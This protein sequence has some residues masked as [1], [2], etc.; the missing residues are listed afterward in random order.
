MYRLLG[1]QE[2]TDV[3]EQKPSRDFVRFLAYQDGE[4]VAVERPGI[5]QRVAP[6]PVGG[7]LRGLVDG[8]GPTWLGVL[9]RDRIVPAEHLLREVEPEPG[10]DRQVLHEVQAAVH[11]AEHPVV[12]VAIELAVRGIAER[13]GVVPQADGLAGGEVPVDVV[14]RDDG[15]HQDILA[16]NVVFAEV[17]VRNPAEGLLARQRDVPAHDE[18][19]HVERGVDA[20]GAALQPVEGRRSLLIQEI[21]RRVV[22][23]V[24]TA[25]RNTQVGV[26]GLSRT[27]YR[28]PPVRPGA[29][30]HDQRRASVGRPW[31]CVR[32]QVERI[33]GLMFTVVRKDERRNRWV[34]AGAINA[35]DGLHR[36]GDRIPLAYATVTHGIAITPLHDLVVLQR[37]G[38]QKIVVATER[39]RDAGSDIQLHFPRSG[40][41]LPRLD[42]HHA[43]AGPRPV[44]RRRRR[45]FQDLDF[46][47]VVGTQPVEVGVR[48]RRTV[49]DVQ[50]IVVLERGDA[51]DS[52]RG[53]RAGRA[54]GIDRDTGNAAIQPLQHTGRGLLLEVLDIDRADRA[55]DIGSAL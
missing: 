48:D 39:R 28:L 31:P 54:A 37:V 13:I 21:E 33:G 7:L 55:G 34:V 18:L 27:E 35:V 50:R 6:R 3:P 36:I 20:Q 41:S 29:A 45:V 8:I 9:R 16:E 22:G 24:R 32:S 49:D 44:N 17:I 53:A 2:V 40:L 12:G 4:V 26:R 10:L 14:D 42:D 51:P 25:S 11:T 46:S 5:V 38:H 19:I 23:V 47:D 43:V 15:L 30:G 52:D 1:I